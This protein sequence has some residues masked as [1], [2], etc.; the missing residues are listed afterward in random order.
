[1]ILFL[2]SS[3][4]D[5]NVP[6]G[7]D[8]PCI[9]DASNGFID[10]LSQC[11]KPDS[12]MVVVCSDPENSEL[13]DEMHD[14]F[15]RVFQH[16]GLTISHSVL[17]DGRNEDQAEELI[18]GSD[19]VLLGGGHVPTQHEFFERIHLRDLLRGYEGIVMGISAGSMNCANPVY[20]QPE[21]PGESIDPDYERFI[22]GLALTSVHVLPHYNQVKDYM[23]DGRRLY[24]DVTFEDSFGHLFYVLMDGSYILV[25]NGRTTLHGEAYLIRNGHM[26][27]IC[28]NGHHITLRA[29]CCFG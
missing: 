24:E 13:N 19:F 12:R 15:Y 6:E 18:L 2:T 23:I 28:E 9:L 29:A 11:W 14:T 5:N 8:L 22:P 25:K 10:K 20:A 27:K 7:V 4:C 17:L 21:L 16:H 26:A 1:M 3:P